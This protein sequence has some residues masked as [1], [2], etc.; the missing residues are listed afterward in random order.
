MSPLKISLSLDLQ[1]IMDVLESLPEGHPL[2]PILTEKRD[3]LIVSQR[4][5]DKAIKTH[6][7]HEVWCLVSRYESDPHDVFPWCTCLSIRE[8]KK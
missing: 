6:H 1:E 5:R 3:L 4:I 2:L 8:E 7:T